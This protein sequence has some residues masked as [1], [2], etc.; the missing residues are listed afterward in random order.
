MAAV[1]LVKMIKIGSKVKTPHGTGIVVQ[2]EVFRTCQRWGV[3]LD[4]NP[5][6]F[7][8]AFYFKEEI[9]KN[10]NA[11]AVNILSQ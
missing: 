6:T 2:E 1:I 10:Q 7:P 5:F 11:I 4:K 9:K 8:I 3:M